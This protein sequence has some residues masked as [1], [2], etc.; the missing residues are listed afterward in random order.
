MGRL[1]LAV[2]LLLLLLAPTACSFHHIKVNA[3]V[4]KL[5]ASGI[6]VGKTT[7]EEVG[8]TLGVPPPDVPTEVGTRFLSGPYVRFATLE[9]RC[10]T[11]GFERLLV[12][13]PFR[14]CSV[15]RTR[16][17]ALEFDE[18]GIVS[19]VI[20]TR[21]KTIWPPFQDEEDRPP[22]VTTVRTGDSR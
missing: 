3:G 15:E 16:E 10:F 2:S 20:D 8:K 11:L 4:M 22:L 14:W 21:R 19:R 12:V 6:V 13:A 1:S 18:N 5:D 9:S 17:L 7:R